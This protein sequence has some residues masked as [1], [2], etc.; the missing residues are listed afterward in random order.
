MNLGRVSRQ[1]SRTCV[2]AQVSLQVG[3]LEV[4]LLAAGEGA[5]VVSSARE[6]CL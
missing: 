5:H 2:C 4:G 1:V 3:T 6:V